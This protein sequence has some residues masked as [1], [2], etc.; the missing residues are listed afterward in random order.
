[1]SQKQN[2]KSEISDFLEMLK[3]QNWF[4]LVFQNN[5]NFFSHELSNLF[6]N[7][8]FLSPIYRILGEIYFFWIR[9]MP[10]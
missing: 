9:G 6:K 8:E 1:M 5:F 7:F 10:F 3:W 2:K 4:S